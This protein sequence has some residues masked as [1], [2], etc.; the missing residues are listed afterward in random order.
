MALA[1]C[2]YARRH[3]PAYKDFLRAA[4]ITSHTSIRTIKSFRNLPLTTK[5][6]Y[7]RA[8]DYIKLFPPSGMHRSTTVSATSGST[9]E[10]FFFPRGTE[11]DAFYERAMRALLV[12]QWDVGTRSTLCLIGFGFGI[13]I[14]GVFTYKN[15]NKLAE[16]GLPMTLVPIGPDVKLYLKS[17]KKFSPHFDQVILMGYPPF[18][19]DVLDAG[20]DEGVDWKSHRLRILTAAEGYS[21]S[22]RNHLAQLTGADPVR[23]MVNIYGTV[24]HGTIAHETALTNMIRRI[25]S[26]REDVFDALFHGAMN[27]PTLAQ[28]YP[29]HIYF[30]VVDGQIVATGYGSS[31]PLVRYAFSDL[32]GVIPFR[33]M[34]ER[35]AAL[36]INMDAELRKY[37][38][39]DTVFPLPFVYVHARADFVIVFRGANIYPEEIRAALDGKV[40]ERWITGK[41]TA[42]RMEQPDM[43]QRLDINVEMR[44]RVKA[45]DNI[46][47]KVTDAIVKELRERNSEFRNNYT[48]HPKASTPNVILH[49]YRDAKF[50]GQGGKQQWVRKSK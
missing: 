30:E 1:L 19:K 34:H 43:T 16:S 41:F 47:R 10:P 5:D 7:L 40:L 48:H 18:I 31:I 9:G 35:L 49:T 3:V 2:D 44:P 13:W 29:D 23:D 50:F 24:E 21:E 22:F 17:F 28:Y 6:T 12:T 46:A 8:S 25:A 20:A 42:I 14:G 36:G 39:G 45:S 4:G 38:I 37:G 33:E 26:E 15:F 32:G 27:I 11:H